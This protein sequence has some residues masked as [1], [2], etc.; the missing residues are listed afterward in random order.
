MLHSA[1]GR[2]TLVATVA[3]SGMA[4]LDAT[5]VNVALPRIGEDFG[6]VDALQWVLTSY[7]LTARVVD[8]AGRC[9]R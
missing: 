9:A 5:V 4:M 2:V 7:L 1:K 8:P 6:A 3:A